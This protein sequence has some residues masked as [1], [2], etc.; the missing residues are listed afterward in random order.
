MK[1]TI[2]SN[3][4]VI[5]VSLFVITASVI[6]GAI[7]WHFASKRTIVALVSSLVLASLFA[8]VFSIIDIIRKIRANRAL[9]QLPYNYNDLLEYKIYKRVGR[10]KKDSFSKKLEKLEIVVPNKYSVWKE[11]ILQ[12]NRKL[13]DNEDFFHFLKYEARD[14]K[15]DRD[16]VAIIATPLEIAILTVFLSIHISKGGNV[17]FALVLVIE[18][19]AFLMFGL[20]KSN[21]RISYVE[22]VMEVLCPKYCKEKKVACD[23]ES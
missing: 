16:Y 6:I 13:L 7:V 14:L 19:L 10:T 3:C 5:I 4:I 18:V 23:V 22:D 2:K 1:E 11:G 15:L 20:M 17:L 12:R 9:K 8:I 21:N